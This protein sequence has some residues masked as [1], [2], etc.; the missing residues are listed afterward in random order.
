MDKYD[1]NTA[2]I[3][4]NLRSGHL[5]ARRFE[6]IKDMI[7]KIK[8]DRPLKIAEIGAGTGIISYLLAGQFRDC[9]FESFD[10]NQGFVKY[11]SRQYARSNLSFNCLNIE[12]EQPKGEYDIVISVDMLHHLNDLRTG[13]NNIRELTKAGGNWIIVEPN[14]WNPYIYLYQLLARGEGLFIQSQAEKEFAASFAIQEKRYA[15]II[16]SAIKQPPLWLVALEKHIENHS[17][18]GGSVVYLLKKR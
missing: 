6:I 15:L 8:H 4:D 17:L 1:E 16:H 7:V 13:I 9:F 12:Q 5:L 10:I 18:L 2:S 11:A 14:I 3:Y